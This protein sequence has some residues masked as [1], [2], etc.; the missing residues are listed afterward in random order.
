MRAYSFSQKVPPISPPRQ[1]GAFTIKGSL[2][3]AAGYRAHKE[4]PLDD[5]SH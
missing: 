1:Q 3:G 5:R 2:A 4:L